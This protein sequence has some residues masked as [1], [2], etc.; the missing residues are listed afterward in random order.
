MD[1]GDLLLGRRLGGVLGVELDVGLR[2]VVDQLDLAAEHAARG[3]DL[4]DRQIHRGDHLLAVDIEAARRVVDAGD[5]DRIV[6]MQVADDER[7]G[8][9]G[10]GADGGGLEKPATIDVHVAPLVLIQKACSKKNARANRD[11]FAAP[12]KITSASLHRPLARLL[13]ARQPRRAIV[14][15]IGSGIPGEQRFLDLA[16]RARAAVGQQMVDRN[17][18]L[19][20]PARHQHGAMAVERLLLGAHQAKRGV[21][22]RAR[23]GGRA[24][25]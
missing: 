3:V 9:R 4:V 11:V 25:P 20:Q 18:V 2:V 23:S 13:G 21:L 12:L 14:E 8:H 22:R 19:R 6:G 15:Q 10:G 5:L 7:T 17:A 1:N 24:R 16:M